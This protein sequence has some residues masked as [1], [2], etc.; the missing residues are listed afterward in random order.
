M[1][2]RASVCGLNHVAGGPCSW[3]RTVAYI[4]SCFHFVFASLLCILHVWLCDTS[5]CTHC[6]NMTLSG[7]RTQSGKQT[8]RTL[9]VVSFNNICLYESSV[10][11]LSTDMSVSGSTN[12]AAVFYTSTL[13]KFLLCHYPRREK[14]RQ[15]FFWHAH[16]IT[17]ASNLP[18]IGRK[19]LGPWVNTHSLIFYW[20]AR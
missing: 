4:G 18:Q 1:L 2:M 8:D 6:T 19:T 20:F 17:I 16:I 7:V 12:S 9:S 11:L 3:I 13:R 10:L 15:H 14:T 5:H